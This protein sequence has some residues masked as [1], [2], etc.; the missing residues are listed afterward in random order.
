M[1]AASEV[2]RKLVVAWMKTTANY[3]ACEA[4]LRRT[5]GVSEQLR[6]LT[7]KVEG[8]MESVQK[9]DVA[10]AEAET[11]KHTAE[12]LQKHAR[13]V[14]ASGGSASVALSLKSRG[15]STETACKS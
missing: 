1:Q 7:V 8:I 10:M 12:L 9:L 6:E 13:C 15:A 4:E 11:A 5:A 14:C 2:L 3:D